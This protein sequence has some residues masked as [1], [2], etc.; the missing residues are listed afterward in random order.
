MT[1]ITRSIPVYEYHVGMVGIE[2]GSPVTKDYQTFVLGDKLGER[3]IKK[4]LKEKGLDGYT[5]LKICKKFNKYAIDVSTFIANAKLV[6]SWDNVNS[7]D[8]KT[9]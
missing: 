6:E 4:V 1:N 5:V 7:D 8:S 9:N 3:G 2:N